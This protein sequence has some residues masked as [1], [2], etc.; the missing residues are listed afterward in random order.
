MARRRDVHIRVFTIPRRPVRRP[1]PAK[2][3]YRAWR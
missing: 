2:L 1:E 3:R